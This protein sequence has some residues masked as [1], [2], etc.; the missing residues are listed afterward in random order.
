VT[1]LLKT[2][3]N[4]LRRYQRQFQHILVDEFQDANVA[5][6][7]LIELLGRTP[8][9]PDNVVVVGDDDRR[10]IDSGAASF[11]A[12]AEFVS[13]FQRPPAHDREHE[14]PVLPTVLALEQN[15]R[16]GG[17]VIAGANRLIAINRTR[18]AP[19]KRLWTARDDGERI[20]IHTCA[21][22]DDE[23][24]AIVDAI[25]S[26]VGESGRWG[27][28]AVL[29]RKHKH[30][31]AI[32]ARLR[33]E[34]MQVIT[35]ESQTGWTTKLPDVIRFVGDRPGAWVDDILG[36]D[37]RAWASSRGVPTLLIETDYRAA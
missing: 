2:R 14:P 35:F 26:M 7:E 31:E 3:P 29:Y 17:H 5:Q 30:R 25:R 6:I 15:F 28:V 4:A 37:E 16:S 32:V 22:P 8:D 33:D 18:F 9:R 12:F 1:Q 24:V 21:G 36:P 11:A 23:A 10:S 27:D 13:R 20:E 34:G 19:D